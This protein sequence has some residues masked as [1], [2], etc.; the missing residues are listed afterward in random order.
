MICSG[1]TRARSASRSTEPQVEVSKNTPGRPAMRS[2][3][4]ARSAI[5]RVGDDELGA[6]MAFAE[7]EQLVGDRRQAEAAVDED[8]DAA[9]RGDLLDRFQLRISDREALRA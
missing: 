4:P 3:R 2:A 8:G 9:F 6:R 1:A 5:A 7:P